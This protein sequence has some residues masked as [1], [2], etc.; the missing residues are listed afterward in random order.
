MKSNSIKYLIHSVLTSISTRVTSGAAATRQYTNITDRS[1]LSPQFNEADKI[2]AQVSRSRLR[3]VS[4]AA[5]YILLTAKN[6]DLIK[7]CAWSR[8]VMTFSDV[9]KYVYAF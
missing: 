2:P 6:Q 4:V 3:A 7:Y 9:M 1:V 5:G 8:N